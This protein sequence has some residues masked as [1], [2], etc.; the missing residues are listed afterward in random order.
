[1]RQVP[2]KIVLRGDKELAKTFIGHASAI[3][4]RLEES[5]L[6]RDLKQDHRY[7]EPFPGALIKC[8]V[9][10]G[11]RTI[12]IVIPVHV[13]K[14][15]REG[16]KCFCNCKF[17]VGIIVEQTGTLDNITGYSQIFVYKVLACFKKREY[18]V[19]EDCLA[20]D[21]T[22][23]IKGQK[24][25][26]I[27]YNEATYTCCTLPASVTACSPLKSEYDVSHNDWRT[28]YRIIPWNGFKLKKWIDK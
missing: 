4:Q 19:Y 17:T 26:L 18:K 20:S 2:P 21:F 8:S 16:L 23:Y 7:Y 13:G 14:R 22:K 6:Y 11:L 24:V 5:M 12:L 3:M 10:H 28:T 1:M 25:V 27:A 9:V 15:I